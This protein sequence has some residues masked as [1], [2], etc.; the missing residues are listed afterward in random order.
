MVTPFA[1]RNLLRREGERRVHS[2]DCVSAFFSSFPLKVISKYFG[3]DFQYTEQGS[4][5]KKPLASL[6]WEPQ[7]TFP[8]PLEEAP[9]TF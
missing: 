1:A 6:A 8:C 9:P 4:W 5:G 7:I 2:W 3:P